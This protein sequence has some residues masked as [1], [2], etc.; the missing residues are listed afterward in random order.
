VDPDSSLRVARIRRQIETAQFPFH[1]GI[2]F[3]QN[4]CVSC[5]HPGLC[6]GNEALVGSKIIRQPGASDPANAWAFL[7]LALVS[8]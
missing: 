5:A 7:D 6:L 4:V 2:R 1:P 3:P 8:I